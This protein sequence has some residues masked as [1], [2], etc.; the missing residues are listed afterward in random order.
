[1]K[2]ENRPTL[3]A[4]EAARAL[5]VTPATIYSWCREGDIPSL[6][7]GGRIRIP[8]AKLADLLGME[9]SDLVEAATGVGNTG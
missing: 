4:Y 2:N 1:M 6:K 3:S 9:I 7:L 8:T 5:G